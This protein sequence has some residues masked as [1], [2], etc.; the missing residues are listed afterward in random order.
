MLQPSRSRRQNNLSAEELAKKLHVHW[1]T[2]NAAENG[3][4]CSIGTIQLY[5]DYFKVSVP[6]L[7]LG[8]APEEAPARLIKANSESFQ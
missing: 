7:L 5:A 1:T 4:N 3:R 6:S 2:I 8:E